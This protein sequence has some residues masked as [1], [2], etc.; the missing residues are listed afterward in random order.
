MQ[1]RCNA[2]Q[3]QPRLSRC[4]HSYARWYISARLRQYRHG[5]PRHRITNELRPIGRTARQCRKNHPRRHP[6][7]IRRDADNGPQRIATR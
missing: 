3:R 7:A 5:A 6:P 2:C 1:A 4:Q